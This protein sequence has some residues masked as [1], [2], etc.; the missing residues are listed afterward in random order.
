MSN[1]SRAII[2]LFLLS[3]LNLSVS[4]YSFTEL[5]KKEYK[6]QIEMNNLLKMESKL[7]DLYLECKARDTV[8]YRTLLDIKNGGLDTIDLE[9]KIAELR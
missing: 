2:I 3:V 8:I 5:N 4:L 1:L 6:V 7:E 9:N